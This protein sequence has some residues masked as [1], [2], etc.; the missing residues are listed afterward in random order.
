MK[1]S[2]VNA[3]KCDVSGVHHRPISDEFLGCRPDEQSG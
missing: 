3:S 2:K 1:A